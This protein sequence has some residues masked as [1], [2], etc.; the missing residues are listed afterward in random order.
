MAEEARD[1]YGRGNM[2]RYSRREDR[3]PEGQQ[4]EW[5]YAASGVGRLGDPLESTRDL[6]GE[7]PSGHRLID[8]PWMKCPTVRGGNL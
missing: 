4:N 3:S 5:K 6:E 8:L 7:K 2:I 1:V